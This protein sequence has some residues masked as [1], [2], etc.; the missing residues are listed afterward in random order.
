MERELVA[1]LRRDVVEVGAVALRED[2]VGE[3]GRVRREHL[4]LEPADRE[5]AALERHLAGH[6]DRVPHGPAR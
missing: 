4:L 1:D 6:P 3:P 5:H 2:H